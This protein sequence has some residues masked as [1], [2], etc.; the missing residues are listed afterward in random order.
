MRCIV[1]LIVGFEVFLVRVVLFWMVLM[2]DS[3]MLIWFVVMIV[4]L[5][6][7]GVSLV[8]GELLV[9][10]VG[11]GVLLGCGVLVL[12]ML[13]GGIVGVVLG[14]LFGVGC[15]DGVRSGGMMKVVVIVSVIIVMRIDRMIQ[16]WL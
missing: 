12:M 13:W 15:L 8:N 16:V 10:G 6:V 3:E 1:I 4:V 14:D 5:G 9:E 11:D 2:C 7:M